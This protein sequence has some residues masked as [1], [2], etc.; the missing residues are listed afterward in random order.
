[1]SERHRVRVTPNLLLSVDEL[2]AALKALPAGDLKNRGR[3][4]LAYLERTFAGERQP[5]AGRN[6]PPKTPE[7]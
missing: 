3:S 1:M 4:A 2:K 6:C 7:I 5:R